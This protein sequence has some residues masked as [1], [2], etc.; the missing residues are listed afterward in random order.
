MSKKKFHGFVKNEGDRPRFILQRQIP[1][2]AKVD[3]D[4][5]YLSVGKKSGTEDEAEFVSWLR[6]NVLPGPEWGFYKEE[7]KPYFSTKV[8]DTAP[9][10]PPPS[11]LPAKGAGKRM[12]KQ[13]RRV[14]PVSGASTS[15]TA[16]QIIEADYNQAT[17]L[18]D[19]CRER[20][21][22]KKALALTQHF[23]NKE[24]HMRYLMRRIEQV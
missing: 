13:K 24:K 22:L 11:K 20:A 3:F 2:G 14:K 21:V 1:Q 18:I 17:G 8:K 23:S 6:G 15:V 9:D 12:T 4:S 16:A 10:T 5:A 7:G 19:K